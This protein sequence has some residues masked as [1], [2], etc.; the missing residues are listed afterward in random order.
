MRRGVAIGL[1]LALG[2]CGGP[3]DRRDGALV[4]WLSGAPTAGDRVALELVTEDGRRFST[5][6]PRPAD[7]R[8]DDFSAVPAGPAEL[9]VT[10]RAAGGEVTAQRRLQVEIV[11]GEA[12]ELRPF[13]GGPSIRVEARGGGRH[14]VWAGPIFVDVEE[15][16]GA[17]RSEVVLEVQ[18]NGRPVSVPPAVGGAWI[19]EID[20][21]LAGDL[22]P[23]ALELRVQACFRDAPGVCAEAV[24]VVEVHRQVWAAALSERPSGAALRLPERGWLVVGD[25]AGGLFVFEEAS[26]APVGRP[27]DVPGGALGAPARLGEVVAVSGREGAVHGFRITEV[28]LAPAWVAPLSA[29]RPSPV[30]AGEE[31]FLVADQAEVL[32]LDPAGGAPAR[33]GRASA[34]ILAAPLPDPGGPVVADLLGQVLALD[35]DGGPRFRVELEGPVYAPVVRDGAGYLVATGAGDLVFL[36]EAG[37]QRAPPRALGAPVVFAPARLGPNRWAV[38]AGRTVRFLD[39][40]AEVEVPLGE[41][42]LG[43][44]APWPGGGVVVGLFNGRVVVARPEGGARTLARLGGLALAPLAFDAPARV[45][46][47]TSLGAFEVLR[48]EDDF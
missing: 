12:L 17:P 5:E 35:A 40:E 16:T 27:Q 11:E 45:A 31:R 30:V 3:L 14:P 8:V 37:G 41:R 29:P 46:L 10:L 23:A 42:V 39:G 47:G 24:E 43:A 28:G 32:A 9:T 7:G 2:G 19:L 6:R 20:P 13:E 15:R 21:R 48:A 36:D 4:V 18:A 25:E 38:A 44:P 1:V 26:G 34:P 22:L 33:L